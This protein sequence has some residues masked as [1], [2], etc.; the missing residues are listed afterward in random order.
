MSE[1]YQTPAPLVRTV[2]PLTDDSLRHLGACLTVRQLRLVIAQWVFENYRD[3]ERV[4][5]VAEF[6]PGLPDAVVSVR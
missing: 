2:R 6:G 1:S 4:S 5:L 3:A